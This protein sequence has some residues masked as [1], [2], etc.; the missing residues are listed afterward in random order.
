MRICYVTRILP[1]HEPGG[2]QEHQWALAEGAARRGHEV[3]VIS[4][5]LP[6]GAGSPD[7]PFHLHLLP[8]TIPGKYRGGFFRAAYEAFVRINAE[9]P[10]DIIHSASFAA[11]GF[12]IENEAPLVATLH[13]VSLAETEYEPAVFRNL[14]AKRRLKCTLRFPKIW[15]ITRRMLSFGARADFIIVDSAFSRRE[16][17]RVAPRV[18]EENVRVVY[19][20]I[21]T[22]RFAPI[23]KQDA[24]ETLG[25]GDGRYALTV[26]R[27][28][29][30]KG[31]QIALR[32]FERL[33]DLG[34]TLLVA[35]DGSY[36][37]TLEQMAREK[38][39]ANVTFLGRVADEDLARY[40]AATDLFLYPELTQPAFG[41][42][43]AEAMAAGC[44]VIGSDHGAIP[45]VIG[46]A[47]RLFPPGDD[48]ALAGE[49]RAFFESGNPDEASPAARNR[50]RERFA[51]DRMIDETLQC[52]ENILTRR[53]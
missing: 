18:R 23:P 26:S 29:P 5:A 32:A 8:G 11:D 4:T 2:M 41:L 37:A 39:L 27:L 28:D 20:G 36:R 22:D 45:E 1:Q 13:G 25:L 52:Y 43:A 40:Y 50:V 46:D 15:Y 12:P 17:L 38:G 34:I 14:S 44:A 9:A 33:R 30:Q 21:D 49:I 19:C 16:L 42:V 35:G 24:R 31:V 3:H 7:A 10:F 51:L 47:G 48:G 53:T 6:A